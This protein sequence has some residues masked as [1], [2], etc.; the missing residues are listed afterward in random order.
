MKALF[1]FAQM[2]PAH[3]NFAEGI[4]ADKIKIGPYKKKSN[5][6]RWYLK[7]LLNI[8]KNY[9]LYIT[10][11]PGFRVIIPIIKLFNRKS[12]FVAL[13]AYEKPYIISKATPAK[14]NKY[15][16]NLEKFDGIITVSPMVKDLLVDIG[17]SKNKIE[18]ARPSAKEEVIKEMKESSPDLNSKN[19]L[20]IGNAMLKR[21]IK[22]LDILV[23]AMKIVRRTNT[24]AK[25]FIVGKDNEKAKETY[26]KLD[27]VEFLGFQEKLSDP[28]KKCSLYAHIGRGDA[29]P[30]STEEAMHAG[31]PTLVSVWT[32]TKDFVEKTEKRF[33]VNLDKE[34]VANAI[35]WY[36][37]LDK[38]EKV[39]LSNNFR[40]TISYLT[41]EESRNEFKDAVYKLIKNE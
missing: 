39:A 15:R 9:D 13:V 25:L 3:S 6:P 23:E 34:S 12:K 37:S 30:I 4:N 18:I 27:F 10:E 11:D 24:D 33:V 36:F 1:V 40:Q 8:S 7:C 26:S 22:G 20:I 41:P 17:V 38:E 14:K 35:N 2:H 5:I 31:L 29:C 21:G 28:M 32:G 16:K 19:V